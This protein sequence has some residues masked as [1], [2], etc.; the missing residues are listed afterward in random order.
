MYSKTCKFSR[1]VNST[2]SSVLRVVG[3][4]S[5]IL[6]I[7]IGFAGIVVY[8]DETTKLIPMIPTLIGLF[9]GYFACLI[10]AAVGESVIVPDFSYTIRID[11]EE[12]FMVFEFSEADYRILKINFEITSKNRK[13]MTLDD[14]CA[15]IRIAYDKSVA[16]FLNGVKK[17]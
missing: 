10:L 1:S 7:I 11:K 3:F 12:T 16:E 14:G 8:R 9:V 17:W 5:A 15:R 4:S 13:Y 2:V 6:G